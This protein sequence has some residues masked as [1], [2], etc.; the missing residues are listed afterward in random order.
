MRE[1]GSGEKVEEERGTRNKYRA[2]A[3]ARR[4]RRRRGEVI[5]KRTKDQGE[6]KKGEKGAECKKIQ[7]EGELEGWWRV[8]V[9]V[10]GGWGG[11]SRPYHL[12][13]LQA[14]VPRIQLGTV[15]SN[16]KRAASWLH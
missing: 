2:G 15:F 9:E 14:R 1:R 4:R 11:C 3:T 6:G 12:Q 16:E 7:A 13:L 10:G 8:V 5:K